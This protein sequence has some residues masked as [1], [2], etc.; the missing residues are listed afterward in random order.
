MAGCA[1]AERSRASAEML[2]PRLHSTY[3]EATTGARLQ[4]PAHAG[5]TPLRHENPARKGRLQASG[6]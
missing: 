1:P 4:S 2:R 5:V 6:K 3:A